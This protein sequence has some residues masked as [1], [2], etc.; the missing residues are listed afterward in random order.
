MI[1]VSGSG[2]CGS[3]LMMHMLDAVGVQTYANDKAAFEHDDL[4]IDADIAK[5]L[6]VIGD[7]ACKIL[8]PYHMRWPERCEVPVIWMDRNFKEQAKSQVKLLRMGSGF[9]IPGQAWR[10]IAKSL[11]MDIPVCMALYRRLG[12]RVLRVRFEE[13]LSEPLLV[14]S[15]VID[16]LGLS[17]DPH[18]MARQ[19]RQRSPNCATDLEMENEYIRR[20]KLQSQS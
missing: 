9:S 19:V 15:R 7:R 2:R 3:T 6:P 4:T 1:I 18:I 12:A 5:L 16:F 13:L 10:A 14:A 17:A 20:D 8:D 11:E